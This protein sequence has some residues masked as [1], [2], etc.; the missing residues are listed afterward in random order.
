MASDYLAVLEHH[1]VEQA[2]LVGHSMGGFLALRFM[3]L[4]PE[5]ARR[6]VAHA[7]LLATFAG[8]VNEGAPQNRLQ[9][10]LIRSG[11]MTWLIGFP[12]LGRAFTRSL[13]GLGYSDAMAEVFIPVFRA[14]NHRALW[15]ILE[16]FGAE[17]HYPRL[18]ELQVPCTVM[19]G[20]R[21]KTS[22]AFHAQTMAKL[23]PGATLRTLPGVGHLANW[24]AADTLAETA[25]ALTAGK[26]TA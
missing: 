26:A 8:R 22:P 12:A 15:P 10:P 18:R 6:R 21:D 1:G 13:V 4:H 11:V 14:A 9:I 20:D 2:V 23:I 19:V 16:A 3:L 24:E 7:I 5:V 17:D 25:L